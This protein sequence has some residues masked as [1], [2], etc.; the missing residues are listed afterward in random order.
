MAEYLVPQE[1]L[2]RAEEL[3]DE[4]LGAVECEVTAYKQ[5]TVE[6]A[7]WRADCHE[8]MR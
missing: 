4:L 3:M 2:E 1:L 7:Q 5:F 8:V 6:V